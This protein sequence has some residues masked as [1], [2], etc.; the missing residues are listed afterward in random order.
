MSPTYSQKA[1]VPPAALS[2]SAVASAMAPTVSRSVKW[3]SIS[4]AGRKELESIGF[5][6]RSW[7]SGARTTQTATSLGPSIYTTVFVALFWFAGSV[8]NNTTTK[9]AMK[10]CPYPLTVAYAG[11]LVQFGAGY[12][13][14]AVWGEKKTTSTKV[15]P[16]V[17]HARPQA[18]TCSH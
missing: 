5:D 6:E 18:I 12:V 3:G 10:S 11:L 14:R 13:Q 4:P 7:D 2:T 17:R 16:W 15:L 8:A 1:L 9:L